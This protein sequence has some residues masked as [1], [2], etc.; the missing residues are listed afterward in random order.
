MLTL[1]VNIASALAFPAVLLDLWQLAS[2]LIYAW[3]LLAHHYNTQLSI[4]WVHSFIEPNLF[5]TNVLFN[6]TTVIYLSNLLWKL[7]LGLRLDLELHYFSI[8]ND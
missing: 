8:F 6:N 4:I 7:G 2:C 5:D 1:V 3:A